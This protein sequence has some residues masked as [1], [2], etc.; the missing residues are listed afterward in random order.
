VS[1]VEQLERDIWPDPGPD[2]SFLVRRC[3]ELRRKPLAELTVED[4]RIMLG[5]AIG[6]PALLPLAVR[7]LLRDPLAEGDYYPGDLLRAVL[8]LPESA[9]SSLRAERGQLAAVLA[10]LVADPALE[11]LRDDIVRFLDR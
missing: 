6:V 11:P 1:T 2:A 10:E 3:A 4:L 5:Q 7:L 9:W 8:R